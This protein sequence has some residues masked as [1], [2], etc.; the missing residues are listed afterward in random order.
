MNQAQM[1]RGARTAVDRG[2][3]ASVDAPAV[4]QAAGLRRLFEGRSTRVMGVVSNPAVAWS[5]AL[6]EHLA[7]AL[8]AAQ[9]HTLVV[10]ASETAPE[11]NE[12]AA[13]DLRWAIEV[14]CK[15]YSYLGARGLIR[16][17][18]D[19][20]GQAAGL[21]RLASDAAPWADVLL[22]QAPAADLGRLFAGHDW[23]P[24]LMCDTTA[25]GAMQAYRSLKSMGHLGLSTF[26]LLLDATT[27]PVLGPRVAMRLIDSASRFLSWPAGVPVVMQSGIGR[28]PAAWSRLN[29]LV[30]A[31]L[32][33]APICNVHRVESTPTAH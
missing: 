4:D 18:V 19:A 10:D 27:R 24:I 32:A 30:R 9:L 13:L 23:R 1:M 31:Q 12:W 6:M 21:L 25:I 7:E 33:Q 22:I 3:L 17:H 5:G 16:Q 20:T 11:A 8:G 2:E 29:D 26:D 14:R 15:T 28:D